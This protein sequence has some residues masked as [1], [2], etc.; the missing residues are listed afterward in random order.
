MYPIFPVRLWRWVLF[1]VAALAL[2]AS[3]S[4]CTYSPPSKTHGD[5]RS[6]YGSP[7][8]WKPWARSVRARIDSGSAPSSLMRGEPK[9][10]AAQRGVKLFDRL[11][12]VA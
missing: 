1:L 12:A 4:R 3:L 6:T 5:K 8:R 10:G 9:G 11:V 7:T 2:T